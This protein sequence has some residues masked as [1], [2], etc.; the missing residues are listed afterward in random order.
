MKLKGEKKFLDF[1]RV[2]IAKRSKRKKGYDSGPSAIINAFLKTIKVENMVE[3]GE[4][5]FKVKKARKGNQ[6]LAQDIKD[7]ITFL[8]FE[9]LN[10]PNP[11]VKHLLVSPKVN[12]DDATP[13]RSKSPIVEEG[14]SFLEQMD[15]ISKSQPR[16]PSGNRRGDNKFAQTQ[17][18]LNNTM[19]SDTGSLMNSAKKSGDANGKTPEM[20]NIIKAPK[21]NKVQP[22]LGLENPKTIDTKVMTVGQKAETLEK[23]RSENIEVEDPVAIDRKSPQITGTTQNQRS[24]GQ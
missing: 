18:S 2:E 9:S 16:P 20:T 24:S 11:T 10:D 4:N 14:D 22:I 8:P 5:T 23:N 3:Y 13:G 21:S 15:Q 17:S 12:M 1:S 7:S 19:K 6:F